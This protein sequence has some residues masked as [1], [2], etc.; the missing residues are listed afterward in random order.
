MP[1]RPA[2]RPRHT[3]RRKGRLVCS[4]KDYAEL[5]SRVVLGQVCAVCGLV[6][7]ETFHHIVPAGQ[8][9]DDVEENG[10]PLCGDGVRGCHGKLTAREL[11]ARV[12]LRVW[13]E[14][15]PTKLTYATVKMGEAW[16]DR[17]YPTGEEHPHG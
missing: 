3:G 8:G 15:Q 7:A 9:G 12:R 17:V 11:E 10:A 13:L 2:R 14:Q 16:L 6:R 5:I 4:A 1:L